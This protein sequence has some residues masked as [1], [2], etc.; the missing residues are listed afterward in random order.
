MSEAP[1]CGGCA[2]IPDSGSTLSSGQLSQGRNDISKPEMTF[3]TIKN[4]K[5]RTAIL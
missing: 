4:Q 3:P 5:L 2:L 1:L